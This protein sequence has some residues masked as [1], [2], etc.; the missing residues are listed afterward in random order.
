LCGAC[1]QQTASVRFFILPIFGK[2]QQYA[3]KRKIAQ[4][5]MEKSG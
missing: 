4:Y 2:I 3:K 1:K 5:F